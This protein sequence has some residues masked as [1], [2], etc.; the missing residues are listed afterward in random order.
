MPGITALRERFADA[1]ITLVIARE[2]AELLPAI[3]GIDRCFIVRRNVRDLAT[4]FALAREKF[5][6]CIDLTE[7]DRS[8]LLT[9]LSG[10][11][12]R[13]VSRRVKAHSQKRARIYNQ[14]ADVR[15]I[16]MHTLDYN[17]GLLAPLGITGASPKLHLELPPSAEQRAGQLLRA[18]NIEKPFIVFH[19]GSARMEKFWQPERWAEVIARVRQQCGV[20][21]VITGGNWSFER[22]HI[23]A[24][25]AKAGGEIVDLSGQTDLLT[26]IALIARASLLVTVD[27]AAMHLAA[28]QGIPQVALFGPTNPFHWRPRESP[29]LI[30]HGDSP[31][32]V[33]EFLPKRER[34]PMNQISTEAVFNAM[35]SLLSAPAARVS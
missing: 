9:F 1:T 28:A 29:A 5:D 16:E 12:R 31:L 8:A 18:H 11:T 33:T 13:I 30:L 32:P 17:L 19:P 14:F 15:L 6:Y 25:K 4:L 35:G 10:A 24:I 23:R 27:S 22:E 26:F 20:S 2:C 21:M 7:N 3:S 34:L